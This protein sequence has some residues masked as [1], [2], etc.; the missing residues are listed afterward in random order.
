ME[1]EI[2][3]I[4]REIKCLADFKADMT[5]K[6]DNRKPAELTYEFINKTNLEMQKQTDELQSL[7]KTL[8]THVQD[9]KVQDAKIQI[10]LEENQAAVFNKFEE[11]QVVMTSFIASASKNYASKSFQK[12][13]VTISGA[14]GLIILGA[15]ATAVFKLIFK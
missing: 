5:Q 7:T 6:F 8:D 4:K 9:Q 11:V 10:K 15:I 14:I 1:T 2:P 13:V 3:L 12:T